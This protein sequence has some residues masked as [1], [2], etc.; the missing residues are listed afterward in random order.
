MAT[1]DG[2]LAAWVYVLDDFEGGMPSART[3]GIL[4]D[5]AEAAGAPATTSPSCAT[6][7]CASGW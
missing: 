5:A 4:A 2:E 3:L 7:P 1:L 6:R